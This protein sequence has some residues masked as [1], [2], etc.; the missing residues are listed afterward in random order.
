MRF[1]GYL[2]GSVLLYLYLAALVFGG[3]LVGSSILLGGHDDADIDGGGDL[4]VDGDLDLD[5]DADVDMDKDLTVGEGADVFWVLKSM[6]FWTFFLA[7]F[8]LTGLTLDGLGLVANEWITLALSIGMGMAL[9]ITA[10]ATIRALSN[11]KNS[12]AAN[13]NDFVGKTARV[14]VPVTPGGLGKVRVRVKGQIVDVLAITD[15]EGITSEDEV[16]VLEM[17]G[18]R[19]RV[20][21]VDVMD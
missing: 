5:A 20:A 16:I 1:R 19:A 8:G 15:E 4:D 13:A 14:M 18:T 10:A 12:E 21:R 3:V 9:G 11:D 17:E 6:R 7:F 2:P